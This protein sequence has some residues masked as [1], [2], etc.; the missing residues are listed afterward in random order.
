L[1]EAGGHLMVGVRSILLFAFGS[2]VTL[3]TATS[4]SASVGKHF[5]RAIFVIFENTNYSSALKEPFFAQL[6]ANGANFTNFQAQ[7][8][9]SQAN[10]VAMTSGSRAG[11]KGDGVVDL[12]VTN[13]VD[14]LEAKGLSW[15]VYAEGFPG[16]CFAGKS[17]GNYVRKHNPFISFDNIRTDASRC[18]K[19]V[20]ASEFNRDVL[21]GTVPDYVFYIP[22][23]RNDGHDTGVAYADKWYDRKFSPLLNDPVF[24]T[25][26][27]L[28][29]TFDESSFLS[30]KNQ[31]YTTIVGGP[32]KV[33]TYAAALTHYSLLQML[34]ENWTLGNL[35]KEDATAQPV[36]DIWH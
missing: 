14:L 25:N 30:P 24:M 1:R 4:G 26:T 23:M 35:G 28:I 3:T 36:P 33:G 19:I 22:D 8:H 5:D 15:K 21:A 20:D 27:I 13:I 10:Y 7:T 34:E 18:A 2:V 17:S 9:P 29:T 12:N 31:I 6:A 16:N 11:V 32:V